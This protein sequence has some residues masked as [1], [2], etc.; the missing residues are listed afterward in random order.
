MLGVGCRMW[1][2][3]CGMYDVGRCKGGEKRATLLGGRDRAYKGERLSR[4]RAA[5]TH[6]ILSRRGA[7]VE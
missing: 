1:D 3:G 6:A 4:R 5:A 7:V 2:V